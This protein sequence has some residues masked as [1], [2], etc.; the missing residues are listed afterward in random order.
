MVEF[1]PAFIKRVEKDIESLVVSR[2]AMS[3][4][5]S[6]FEFQINPETLRAEIP[7][8]FL[9]DLLSYITHLKNNK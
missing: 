2:S 8:E 9:E 6:Y 3:I 7:L 4:K 5:L 1:D